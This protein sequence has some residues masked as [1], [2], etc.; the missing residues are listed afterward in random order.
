MS[1]I[2]T[3]NTTNFLQKQS[4]TDK[5]NCNKKARGNESDDSN[6]KSSD[7]QDSAIDMNSNALAENGHCSDNSNIQQSKKVMIKHKSTSGIT[8]KNKKDKNRNKLNNFHA[9]SK[10]PVRS[11]LSLF[12][13]HS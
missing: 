5:K 4:K 2:I 10:Q 9:R 13:E 12:V 6:V 11:V 3:I 7:A 8:R 1:N